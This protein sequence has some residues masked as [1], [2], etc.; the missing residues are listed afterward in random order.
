MIEVRR[1]AGRRSTL[2]FVRFPVSL[3][4]DY[5]NWV[6]PLWSAERAAYLPGGNAVLERS[7]H[8]MFAAYS[9]DGMVGRIVAYIDPR[10][11]EHFSAKMGFFG[12]FECVDDEKAMR[13]LMSAAG[14]WL[15][16]RGMDAIRGPINPV[17]EC[18]GLLVDGFE[19]PPVYL[20]P[21]NPPYYDRLMRAA[22][23]TGVKDLIAYEADAAAGYAVPERFRRFESIIAARRPSITTRT[24]DSSNLERDAEHIRSILNAS[25]DGNWGYVP[26]GREETA[27]LIR[28]LKPILDPS[29]I[30]FV[31]DGG[32]PV[33][34]CLGFPDVNVIIKSIRGRLFPTGFLR[35]I[36]GA[37]RLRDYR[38]W[39]LAIL[40][41]YQ[42]LGL[43]VLLYL[44]L[45]DAL[46]CRNVRLEANYILEDN[47]R[48]RNALVK[49]GMRRIKR[50][51]V[52]EKDLE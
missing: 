35:L 45:A 8:A 41:A 16:E 24:I 28:D 20:S 22:G 48:I 42:S 37:K 6:P 26:V 12:S 1:I 4:R 52:Y 36:S 2:A 38:L 44:R 11:N 32:V 9:G 17:A 3:Y 46:A 29:A 7:E 13:A 43:D 19:T 27:G 14:D 21:F 18:W 34:C 50:Y 39:G 49:L 15:S 40:P 33:G 10:F 30:W 25:V 51:R 5:P 23:F 31:E 47:M